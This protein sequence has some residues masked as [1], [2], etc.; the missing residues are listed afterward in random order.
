MSPIKIHELARVATVHVKHSTCHYHRVIEEYVYTSV[1]RC[2]YVCV[3]VCNLKNMQ[4]NRR[5]NRQRLS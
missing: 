4:G 2:V 3:C 1:C 5:T